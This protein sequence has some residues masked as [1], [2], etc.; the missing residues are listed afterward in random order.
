MNRTSTKR[1]SKGRQDFREIGAGCARE[2]SSRERG[3]RLPFNWVGKTLLQQRRPESRRPQISVGLEDF[4]RPGGEYYCT[5]P[6]Q[7]RGKCA[8]FFLDSGFRY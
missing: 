3:V 4:D 1:G 7:I 8:Q 2:A 5:P 6:T